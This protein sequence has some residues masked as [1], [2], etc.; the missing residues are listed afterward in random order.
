M[1]YSTCIQNSA[2]LASAVPEIRLVSD[3]PN[4]YNGSRDLTTTLSKDGLSSGGWHLLRSAYQPNLK[5]L[6]TPNMKI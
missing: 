6:P 1:T 4:N 2:T 5:S 3:D